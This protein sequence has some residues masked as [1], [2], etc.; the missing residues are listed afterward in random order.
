MYG[1][2]A[3]LRAKPGQVKRILEAEMDSGVEGFVAAYAFRSDDDPNELRPVGVF[4]S[5]EAYLANAAS[6][7]QR[8]RYTQLRAGL[9]AD[10]EWHDGQVLVASTAGSS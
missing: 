8:A 1:T 7:E 4:E 10:P 5:K 6:A 2:V 3:R 9:E